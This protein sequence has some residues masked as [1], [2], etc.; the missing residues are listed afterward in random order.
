MRP[1]FRQFLIWGGYLGL[2]IVLM[3]ATPVH[4]EKKKVSLRADQLYYDEVKQQL[5]ASGNASL[6]YE[7]GE[8]F[9]PHLILDT[10]QNRIMSTGNIIIQSG[11]QE[12]TAHS[13][14]LDLKNNYMQMDDAQVTLVPDGSTNNI[15]IRAERISD[16]NDTL[17]EGKNAW[18]TTCE[19]E[20]PHYYMYANSFLYYPGDKV[21]GHYVTFYN[22]IWFIPF[23]F[24][25]PMYVF[26]LSTR[27]VVYL[28]PI[29]GSN[30][31]EGTFYKSTFDYYFGADKFG[32]V[33]VDLMTEKGVGLGWKHNY[34]FLDNRFEGFGFHYQ[35]L[36][37][38][39]TASEWENT[40][41]ITD[42]L[43]FTNRWKEQNVYLISGGRTE[44]KQ[45]GYEMVYD[46]L[47]DIHR[48]KFDSNENTLTSV[49][50][51]T[52]AFN[53]D[54]IYNN[55]RRWGI[56]YNKSEASRVNE[57]LTL[58][59]NHALPYNFE[60]SNKFDYTKNEVSSDEDLFDE[61]LR[62]DSML[63]NST[64]KWG[65]FSLQQTDFFDLDGDR[66]DTDTNTFVKKKPEFVWASTP[67]DWGAWSLTETIT[68]GEYEEARLQ[69]N[70][71]IRS[72]TA[73][74]T[75]FNQ[76][77]RGTWTDLPLN[78]DFSLNAGYEQFLY[79]TDD[80][81][82]KTSLGA[83]YKTDW[84]DFF[85]TDTGY[86]RDFIPE[87]S[88][89]PF[90]FDNRDLLDVNRLNEKITFYYESVTKY[91]WDLST[92][93]DY[94]KD[95]QLDYR[96]NLLI[97]PSPSFSLSMNSGYRIEEDIYD[98]VNGVINYRYRTRFRLSGQFS[99]DANI[100][101][102]SSVSNS[103]EGTVG[104]TWQSRWTFKTTFTYQPLIHPDYQLQTITLT[105]DLHRRKLSLSYDRLLEEYRLTMSI[106]AFPDDDFGLSENKHED[107]KFEGLFDDDSVQRY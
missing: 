51:R 55:R 10:A 75:I 19:Y 11:E 77:A 17:K 27:K 16:T 30:K 20:D 86:Q 66:V 100:G 96:S 54:R 87:E 42:T 3:G 67:Y 14:L 13:L 93:Y 85:M 63:R 34:K 56:K 76:N 64:R 45:E 47:G 4:A 22:P 39:D 46:D 79:S 33:Y 103:Y 38:R 92:G 9:A 60:I 35:V 91:K 5:V 15:F 94:I 25:T 58:T 71:E 102:M 106:N 7:Q 52:S 1:I 50:S 2:A 95:E 57:S 31:V 84:W 12:I 18:V 41:H 40:T 104:S 70:R 28:M 48:L 101:E 74:R 98:P 69:S 8:V 80:Q 65:T 105:K 107:L 43:S 90:F 81:S 53:Y 59:E 61:T 99:Y 29:M 68:V 88:N 72:F 89:S 23:A 24:W 82:Y 62:T 26:D 73:N 49:T 83:N 44:R 36:D 21:V 37:E 78:A 97:A 32:K 6:G